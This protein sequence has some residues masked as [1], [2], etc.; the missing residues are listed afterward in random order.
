MVE[1]NVLHI[2]VSNG[3]KHVKKK[4]DLKEVMR[5]GGQGLKPWQSSLST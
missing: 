5:V 1:K 2:S 4:I 3:C